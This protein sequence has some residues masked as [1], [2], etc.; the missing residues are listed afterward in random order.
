MGMR[1]STGSRGGII[2]KL[3]FSAFGLF[4]AFIG[5]QFVKQ[6]WKT[7]Q[8]TKAMQQWTQAACTIVS[9]EVK[10]DGEDFRLAVSYRYQ[11]NG[12]TYTAERYG[13]NKHLTKETIVEID[14]VHKRFPEGKST[15]C[16]YNSANPAEAVLIRPTVQ[17]ARTSVGMTFLFPG[18][19]LLFAMLPWLGGRRNKKTQ[20]GRMSKTKTRK[21]PG[22]LAPVLFGAIFAAVGLAV[23][24][25]LVL[26]P[27]QK[28]KDAQTWHSL[29]ATVVSSKVKSHTSDDSTTYSPYIAYR[30]E[31]NGE[32]YL[33]DRYSFM[34]GSSSGYEGKAAIVRQYPKGRT[35][36]VYVNP[37][38]PA[39]S[40]INRDA[41]RSLFVGLIPLLFFAVGVIII[42]AGFRARKAKLDPA[43][44][45]EHVVALKG[46]SPSRKAVG[47]TLFAAVWNGIVFFIFKSDAPI[48]FHIIFG[49]AGII[50][51]GASI[52]AILAIFN[53]RPNVEITPGDIRP[54]TSVAMRW[55]TMGRADRIGK[56]VITLQCL[57]IT[58]ETRRSGGKSQTTTVKTPIL[59]QEL[60]QTGSPNEIAQGTLQ[61]QIPEEQSASRPGNHGGIRWQLIF[62][63]D[64]LRWPD[65]KQELPFTVYPADEIKH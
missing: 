21:Q 39:E 60:L 56:L 16:H 26:T 4:F 18:F 36:N 51:I 11:V 15:V 35:F 27:L 55:R 37:A 23:L 62:H 10:D 58:T 9:S 45:R 30:Y 3:L 19:G 1:I 47:L 6:E 48:I 31:V 50:M 40:V 49:G 2:G 32:E 52:H 34:G 13:K 22:K 63:G 65:L 38:D 12:Q 41:S 20:P 17:S 33:G 8:E 57:R 44:A 53:P 59:T 42:I 64:I 43:Q 24:K 46:S 7:L 25:P 14:Q 29:P 54:G 61:F 28:T 5:T